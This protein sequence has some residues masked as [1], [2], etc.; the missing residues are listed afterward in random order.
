MEML[1]SD[2]RANTKK[3]YKVTAYRT[4]GIAR[5]NPHVVGNY[6]WYWQANFVSWIWHYMFGF[7]CNTWKL[8]GAPTN[9]A[10][11]FTEQ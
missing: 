4:Y 11:C 10:S 3:P 1:E 2:N 5:L 7:S 9:Q 6:R 8:E